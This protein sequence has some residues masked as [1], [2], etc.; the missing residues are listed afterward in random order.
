MQICIE[1]TDTFAGEANYSWVRRELI[2]AP[3][4]LPTPAVVRR[5]K[6]ALG[7]RGPHVTED[8]GDA[9]TIKPRNACMVVFV[10]FDVTE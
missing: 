1:M 5:V 9:L 2:H 6:R 10:N 8:Y 3:D 4:D 7:L